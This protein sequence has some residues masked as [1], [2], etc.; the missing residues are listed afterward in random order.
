MGHA[1]ALLGLKNMTRL[2][3]VRDAVVRRRLSVRRTEALV[4]RENTSVENLER[5]S[6]ACSPIETAFETTLGAR[7]RFCKKGSRTICTLSFPSAERF[8]SFPEKLGI[9]PDALPDG[10]PP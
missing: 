2:R 6:P 1:Q 3:P 10:G 7:V 9:R 4:L 8:R 5:P